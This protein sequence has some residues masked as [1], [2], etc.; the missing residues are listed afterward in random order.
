MP[1]SGFYKCVVGIQVVYIYL[2]KKKA[3]GGL[4]KV[5]LGPKGDG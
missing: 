1:T 4:A 3:R 5:V 2:S